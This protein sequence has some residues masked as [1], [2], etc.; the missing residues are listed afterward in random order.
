MRERLI[1]TRKWMRIGIVLLVLT[2][3]AV[4]FRRIA[5][6]QIW[7]AKAEEIQDSER[8]GPGREEK[9]D[10]IRPEEIQ[11]ERAEKCYDGKREASLTGYY[12]EKKVENKVTV[13]SN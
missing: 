9:G 6:D 5:S 1:R 11:W 8:K 7:Q 10:F 12:G 13:C 4:V 2:V 3:S